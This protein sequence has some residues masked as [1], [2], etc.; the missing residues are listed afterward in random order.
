M[1]PTPTPRKRGRPP[2]GGLKRPHRVVVYLSPEEM[3]RLE[4]AAAPHTPATYLRNVAIKSK[5]P[6]R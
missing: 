6:A 3:A 1:T 4:S 5:T 2:Q